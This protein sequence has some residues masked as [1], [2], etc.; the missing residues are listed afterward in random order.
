MICIVFNE[1]LNPPFFSFESH[2]PFSHSTILIQY[3]KGTLSQTL[4]S[5]ILLHIF[6]CYLSPYSPLF[7]DTQH[8]FTTSPHHPTTGSSLP[9]SLR[10]ASENPYQSV[11]RS[12]LYALSPP[13]HTAANT[14]SRCTLHKY[15]LAADVPGRI[16]AASP[17]AYHNTPDSPRDARFRPGSYTTSD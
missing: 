9:L 6:Y 8:D 14:D 5:G 11:P 1:S 2:F 16:R 15:P 17:L 4:S 13:P 3:I 10:T 12:P 7:S